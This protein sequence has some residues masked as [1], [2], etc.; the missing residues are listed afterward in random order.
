MCRMILAAGKIE[1][2]QLVDGLLLMA[3]DR[4]ELHENNRDRHG[5]FTH[6][7]GWG[8]VFLENGELRDRKSQLYCLNDPEINALKTISTGLALLHARLASSGR[9]GVQDPHPFLKTFPGLGNFYFTHNGT[10]RDEII[11]NGSMQPDGDTDSERWFCCMLSD[12]AAGGVD[13]VK[14]R[15]RELKVYSGANFFF[16]NSEFALAAVH[17]NLDPESIP[18]ARGIPTPEYYTM[19]LGK[20]AE[21]IYVSSEKIPIPGVEWRTLAE[22]ELVLINLRTLECSVSSIY[23]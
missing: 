1:M 23:C 19:K 11:C 4:N 10:I 22:G 3:S 17:Y 12:F 13:A 15:V 7:D 8:V 6:E 16:G 14:K 2:T 18:T 5:G 21:A 9:R 20:S